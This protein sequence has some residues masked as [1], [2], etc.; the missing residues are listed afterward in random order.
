M[1]R[2]S[3]SFSMWKEI[4]Q[5]ST[6]LQLLLL[7]LL[8]L[9]SPLLLSASCQG[10]ATNQSEISGNER[11]WK[12]PSRC[13][14]KWMMEGYIMA[15]NVN[16]QWLIVIQPRTETT[17]F[18]INTKRT[19][20]LSIIIMIENREGSMYRYF[21]IKACYYPMLSSSDIFRYL[22]HFLPIDSHKSTSPCRRWAMV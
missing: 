18:A 1:Q 15:S 13:W 7:T 10:P 8:L 19:M 2:K 12:G 21:T 9:I 3:I 14:K 16:E 22:M 17:M 11:M 6:G 4:N 20:K 5:Q